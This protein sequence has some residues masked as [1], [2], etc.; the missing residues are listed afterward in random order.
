MSLLKEP[1][2]HFLVLALGLFAVHDLISHEDPEA[3]ER[4]IVVDRT[5]LLNFIQYRTKSFDVAAAESQLASLTDDSLTQVI[6]DYVREEALAREARSL[7]LDRNDYVIKR[8]LIQKIDYI[9]QGFADAQSTV[10]DDDIRAYYDDHKQDYFIEPRITFTHIFFSSER[11]GMDQAMDL[12]AQ[13]LAQ[14]RQDRAGFNEA[15]RYGERYLYGLNYVERSELYVESHF[16]EA[17]T[18][19]LFALA[20]DS[21]TW[22]GPMQSTFGSHLVMVTGRQ[23]GRIPPLEEV[24]ARVAEQAGRAI[25]A[26]RARE[27]TQQIVDSYEVDVVFNR[28]PLTN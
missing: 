25:T 18:A 4:R 28:A 20:P 10:T 14:V 26:E 5:N 16:G 1:L 24:R 23:A 3:D 22:H 8:R 11:H 13:T 2:L 15:S 9:A 19:E 21:A 27:A 6:D 12:A 17:M 7:G